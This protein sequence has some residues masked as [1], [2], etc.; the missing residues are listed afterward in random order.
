MTR[1]DRCTR[2]WLSIDKHNTSEKH[3]HNNVPHTT[4]PAPF[5]AESADLNSS[6]L[7][8]FPLFRFW[9]FFFD[10]VLPPRAATEAS[11]VSPT[12]AYNTSHRSMPYGTK[13]AV[14]QH[15]AA[16]TVDKTNWRLTSNWH[17]LSKSLLD[18]TENDFYQ[19]TMSSYMYI[20][21]FKLIFHTCI[22]KKKQNF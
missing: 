8:D 22:T 9:G 11:L 20:L 21:H 13:P 19:F 6:F 10:D 18:I 7:F 1:L 12:S 14:F 3:Q 15:L 2:H 5:T 16:Q 4:W 17:N